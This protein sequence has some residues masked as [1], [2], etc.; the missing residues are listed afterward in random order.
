MTHLTLWLTGFIVSGD[1]LGKQE[2]E[3]MKLKGDFEQAA[4][5]LGQAG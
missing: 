2:E 4:Q 5:A 3:V 1:Q